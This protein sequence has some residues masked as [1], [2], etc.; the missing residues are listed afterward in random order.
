VV[1]R[2]EPEADPTLV[3]AAIISLSFQMVSVFIG[4][5]ARI[6]EEPS[7]VGDGRFNPETAP[8]RGLSVRRTARTKAC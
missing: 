5:R 1:R 7:V 3:E 6:L 8:A 2:A 4:N